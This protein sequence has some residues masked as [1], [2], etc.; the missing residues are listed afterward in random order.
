M[1]DFKDIPHMLRN[2]DREAALLS[3]EA[4]LDEIDGP[5]SEEFDDD[6]PVREFNPLFTVWEQIEI[7]HREVERRPDNPRSWK[8]LGYAYM[9]AGGYVP[10]LLYLAE[11][12]LQASIARYDESPL[13]DNLK[14]K[15]GIV[16]R[17]RQGD[18]DAHVEL[19]GLEAGIA[20][21]FEE[22]PEKV[23]VPR[24]FFENN[25]ID[26]PDIEITK[27]T[28]AMGILEEET[29]YEPEEIPSNGYSG[30]LGNGIQNN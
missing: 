3:Y 22:F 9:C 23:P 19:L 16:E 18:N 21:A 27:S 25:I 26:S 14:D 29:E 2:G 30:D 6:D 28:L 4:Y 1:V 13:I 8:L 12:C 5:S 24:V 11:H 17:A 7:Y 15:L 20:G 10:V